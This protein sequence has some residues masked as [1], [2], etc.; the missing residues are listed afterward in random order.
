MRT[1]PE[2]GSTLGNRL[3]NQKASW[4]SLKHGLS[5]FCCLLSATIP[6]LSVCIVASLSNEQA[7]APH[8]SWL[9]RDMQPTRTRNYS[10]WDRR[11]ENRQQSITW[12]AAFMSLLDWRA[13]VHKTIGFKQLVSCSSDDRRTL[14]RSGFAISSILAVSK[15]SK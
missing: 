11:G 15:P 4:W 9:S 13:C 3:S 14:L 12:A 1:K 6:K 7:R 5:S 10:K 2:F 8:S